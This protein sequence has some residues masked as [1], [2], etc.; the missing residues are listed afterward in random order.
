VKHRQHKG[1]N[2]RAEHS[3][4]PTRLREK[5]MRRFTS[6]KQAQRFLSA[7][8][9]HCWA[10]STAQAPLVQKANTVPFYQANSWSRTRSP[11]ENSW[12]N[13]RS[14]PVFHCL[15]SLSSL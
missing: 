9:A 13:G 5:N 8:R 12:H 4:Q 7:D 10:C 14:S 1:L 11:Q 6:A 2:N 15:R 3:H